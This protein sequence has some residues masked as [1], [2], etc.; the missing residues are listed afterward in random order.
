MLS[1]AQVNT[2]DSGASLSASFVDNPWG[3]AVV[4]VKSPFAGSYVALV[5]VSNCNGAAP[6]SI[7]IVQSSNLGMSDDTSTVS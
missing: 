3:L 1:I 6:G 5:G 4:I 7:K 2:N